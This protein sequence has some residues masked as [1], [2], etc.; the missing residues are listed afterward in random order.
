[1]F[2]DPQDEPIA[3]RFSPRSIAGIQQTPAGHRHARTSPLS[4]TPTDAEPNGRSREELEPLAIGQAPT[5]K[6]E[7]LLFRRQPSRARPHVPL[8]TRLAGQADHPPAGRQ[9]GQYRCVRT[10]MVQYARKAFHLV[11][12]ALRIGNLRN[13]EG[14]FH[15]VGS[16]AP[17]WG[18]PPYRY[19]HPLG[20]GKIDHQ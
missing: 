16:R 20:A 2:P 8:I 12:G 15:G 7:A 13:T 5:I 10:F 11:T 17:A 18:K 4:Q 3:H 14:T 6:D 1:M 19:A 9:P